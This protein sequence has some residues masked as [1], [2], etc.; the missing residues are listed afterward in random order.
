MKVFHLFVITII[1]V[2]VQSILVRV[3]EESLID[4]KDDNGMT[5]DEITL[6]NETEPRPMGKNL[7]YTKPKYIHDHALIIGISVTLLVIIVM[8]IIYFACSEKKEEKDKE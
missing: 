2:C 7:D 5:A 4:K 1:I 3:D 6:K 8:F